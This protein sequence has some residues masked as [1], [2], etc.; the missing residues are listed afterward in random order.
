MERCEYV[1]R[2]LNK[3]ASPVYWSG[4]QLAQ[5]DYNL[6]TYVE[7]EN[8]RRLWYRYRS[9]WFQSRD[10]FLN[11]EG[12]QWEKCF[13]P[14]EAKFSEELYTYFKSTIKAIQNYVQR[15]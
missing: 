9:D 13:D 1:S 11:I 2:M 12:I 10:F 6:R 14:M 4:A 7:N 15:E 5:L 3:K 8:R